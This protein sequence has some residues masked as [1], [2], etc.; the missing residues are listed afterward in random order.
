MYSPV[1]TFANGWQA[2]GQ[3]RSGSKLR[4]PDQPQATSSRFCAPAD[5]AAAEDSRA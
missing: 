4:L 3:P 1:I 5:V 2:A